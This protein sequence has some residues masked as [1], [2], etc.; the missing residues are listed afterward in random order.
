M[1]GAGY[2]GIPIPC[3]E[4]RNILIRTRAQIF[5]AALPEHQGSPGNE[6]GPFILSEPTPSYSS[7]PIPHQPTFEHFTDPIPP[8]PPPS[9]IEPPASPSSEFPIPRRQRGHSFTFGTGSGS[10][11]SLL[12]DTSSSSEKGKDSW[13]VFPRGESLSRPH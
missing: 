10:R 4:D 2:G 3:V 8:I 12:S 6:F 9:A 11:A 5:N 7:P 1:L 13:K